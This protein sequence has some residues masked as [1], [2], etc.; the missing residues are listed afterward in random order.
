[1]SSAISF[2]LTTDLNGN[3]DK[4]DVPVPL[5]GDFTMPE[6]TRY[7]VTVNIGDSI[8]FK[9]DPITVISGKLTSEVF[10]INIL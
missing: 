3:F 6:T 8:V 2:K 9:V 7:Y 1:M 10:N 5:D 4:N